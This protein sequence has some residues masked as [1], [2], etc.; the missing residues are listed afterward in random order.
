MPPR[1]GCLACFSQTR[2]VGERYILKDAPALRPPLGREEE[3]PQSPPI[4]LFRPLIYDCFG[5]QSS[6]QAENPFEPKD[7]EAVAD[8]LVVQDFG[9]LLSR[10]ASPPPFSP[11]VAPYRGSKEEEQYG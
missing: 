7:H 11:D 1:F 4:L 9:E 5:W 2:A 10:L 8:G 3:L 6:G